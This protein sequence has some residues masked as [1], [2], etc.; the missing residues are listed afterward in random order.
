MKETFVIVGTVIGG[1]AFLYGVEFTWNLLIKAPQALDKERSKESDELRNK[2]RAIT[3]RP[4][5]TTAEEHHYQ[6]ACAALKKIG[7][8]AETV[9]QHLAI[10]GTL[11]FNNYDPPLPKGLPAMKVREIL[12]L[13]VNEHLVTVDTSAQRG[14]FDYVYQIAPG[15]KAALDELLYI[16]I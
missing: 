15:M 16:K 10:Q 3:D 2:I 8:D 13:C 7:P 6:I 12:T 5:R 11:K 14:G 9:L 1:Y 4:K